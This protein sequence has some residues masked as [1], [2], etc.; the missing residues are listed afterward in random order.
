MPE[1]RLPLDQGWNAT[2][3]DTSNDT[4][5]IYTG[6]VLLMGVYVNTVLSAHT[7]VIQDG[8]TA[9]VTL[10]A[11]LAA[12]SERFFYGARFMTS[13]VVNPDDSSTGNITVFWK[14]LS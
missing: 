12:G 3:V 7:V 10:P 4:V 11:S 13:L 1:L 8:S 6:P 2:T 5:T 14:P 9:V